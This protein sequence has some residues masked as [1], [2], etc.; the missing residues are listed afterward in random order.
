MKKK[1]TKKRETQEDKISR[2]L[3]A[4]IEKHSGSSATITGCSF[5]GVQFD[6]AAT[7]AITTIAEGL[8]QNAKALGN[9]ALVLK[10]SNVEVDTFI[11]IGE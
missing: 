2:L 10:A 9:L 6:E 8:L 4:A 5:T 3:D 7:E 1:T 11:K